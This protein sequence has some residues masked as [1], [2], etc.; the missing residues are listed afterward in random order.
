MC[1][2][3]WLAVP[4]P[5]P[6]GEGVQEVEEHVH[7]EEH[8][9]DN[10]NKEAAGG[11]AQKPGEAVDRGGPTGRCEQSWHACMAPSYH[12]MS[13]SNPLFVLLAHQRHG[14]RENQ[15]ARQAGA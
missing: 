14:E 7:A 13:S 1:D 8:A 10:V 5:A 2:P 4:G 11:G 6:D 12:G 9:H 3:A 15:A